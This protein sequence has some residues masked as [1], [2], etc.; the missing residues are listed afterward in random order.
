VLCTAIFAQESS[1]G[2]CADGDWGCWA[3][4]V[5][6]GLALSGVYLLISRT[7]RRSTNDYYKRRKWEQ[8]LR[9]H[10]PDMAKPDEEAQ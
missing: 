1:E 2:F 5:V 3:M 9:A 7:R 10:D 4:V 6:I 8:D